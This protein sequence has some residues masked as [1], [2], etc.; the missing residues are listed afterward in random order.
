MLI[1]NR[2]NFFL[3]QFL[4]ITLFAFLFPNTAAFGSDEKDEQIQNLINQIN[5]IDKQRQKEA[6]EFKDI[7]QK[8]EERDKRRQEEIEALKEKI[9]D[10]EMAL[11][12][13]EK[14]KETESALKVVKD[15]L[16][17]VTDKLRLYG[18]FRLRSEIDANRADQK[19]PRFRERIRLRLGA[20]YKIYDDQLLVGARVRTGSSSDPRSPYAN[21]ED[22][23]ESLEISLDR[24]YLKYTPA[25][26]RQS[27]FYGGKFAHQFKTKSVYNELVWDQ[28]VQ[29]QGFAA[30][31]KGIYNGVIDEAYTT[32]GWYF[33]DREDDDYFWQW[34]AQASITKSF[35]TNWKAILAV[36]TYLYGDT[37]PGG[38]TTF[39][40]SPRNRGNAVENDNFV[41]DFYILDS[42]LDIEY[43]GFSMPIIITGQYFHN[44]GSEINEDDGFAVGAQVGKANTPKDWKLYYQFHRVEQ[45]SIFT[46]FSQDDFLL[47]TNFRGHVAGITYRISKRFD[48]NLWTMITKRDNTFGGELSDDNEI[49]TRLDLNVKF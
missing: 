41:S 4:V 25:F 13:D 24:A 38:S 39:V 6:A 2:T 10:I 30:T 35:A 21:L 12:S 43:S 15:K 32:V 11:P 27:S 3:L 7:I 16:E 20:E 44:F 14:K 22:G 46:P 31:Y 28:D 19:D 1:V 47:A 8:M 23:F 36:G 9:N 48:I 29:P 5:K 18:D 45:D 26:F 33:V 37:T 34:V 17:P 49:R 42:F 40:N